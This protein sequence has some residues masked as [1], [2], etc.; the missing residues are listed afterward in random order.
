MAANVEVAKK[1]VRIK[2]ESQGLREELVLN[3]MN[4]K[5]D[6]KKKEEGM[7]KARD[8]SIISS[9]KARKMEHIRLITDAPQSHDPLMSQMKISGA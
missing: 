3:N 1:A 2:Q 7:K 4:K 9:E 6:E 8:Q 5:L